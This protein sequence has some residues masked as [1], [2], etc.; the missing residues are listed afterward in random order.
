MAQVELLSRRGPTLRFCCRQGPSQ[1]R[2]RGEDGFRVHSAY[3]N[4]ML[5]RFRCKCP[6]S[7]LLR[8]RGRPEVYTQGWMHFLQPIPLLGSSPVAW[9][10]GSVE[11]PRQ[12]IQDFSAGGNEAADMCG[13]VFGKR[14]LIRERPCVQVRSG[15]GTPT[16]SLEAGR[17]C[18]MFFPGNP[19]P[20]NY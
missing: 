4:F 8:I 13:Y 1:A 3:T 12:A 2:A 10:S 9:A 15:R 7:K 16:A 6:D 20:R 18:A 5:D 19:K 11:W 14:M 17:A